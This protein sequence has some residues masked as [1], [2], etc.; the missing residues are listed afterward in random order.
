MSKCADCFRYRMKEKEI[1]A[2]KYEMALMEVELKRFNDERECLFT[3]RAK[4][5]DA[6]AVMARQ[7]AHAHAAAYGANIIGG[8]GGGGGGAAWGMQNPLGQQHAS[9]MAQALAQQNVVAAQGVP[10][11]NLFAG[12]GIAGV[13]GAGGVSGYGGSGSS[14][15]N[16]GNGQALTH[17][18]A[19]CE[20]HQRW[21]SECSHLRVTLG[22]RLARWG[23]MLK[24]CASV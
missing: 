19:W 24:G 15:G 22:Q 9:A 2:L 21:A 3:A 14:G 12:V 17:S 20:T 8:G 5:M 6:Q 7:Q 23:A 10:P 11:G 1:A 4:A 13:A 18:E 16:G